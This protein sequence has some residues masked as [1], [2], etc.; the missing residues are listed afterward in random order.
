MLPPP[1]E[2]AST[3]NL[4]F[5]PLLTLISLCL[6]VT[7]SSLHAVFALIAPLLT[8]AHPFF[9]LAS[10]KT[11]RI[12][13]PL[14]LASLSLLV[15]GFAT[16]LW[17]V[18]VP[19]VPLA[20][21]VLYGLHPKIKWVAVLQKL[22]YLFTGLSYAHFS[23][24]LYP[25][26]Y[27]SIGVAVYSA[28]LVAGSAGDISE[29]ARKF[30][31]VAIRAVP[32]SLSCFTIAFLL[33]ISFTLEPSIPH[34]EIIFNNTVSTPN[35]NATMEEVL[36]SILEGMERKEIPADEYAIGQLKTVGVLFLV[37]M[38]IIGF[39]LLLLKASELI[40]RALKKTKNDHHPVELQLIEIK[41][42]KLD[43]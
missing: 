8:P 35:Q 11:R 16:K 34:Y 4:I 38:L 29:K 17:L 23:V 24:L 21:G 28:V 36:V 14:T 41:T 6:A 40:G 13:L 9:E 5:S 3:I 19:S 20:L 27:G 26:P 18:A 22:V 25:E 39:E 30:V 32:L 7:A 1:V 12:P 2:S 43:D 15:I 10:S 37:G 31:P 42:D 33:M